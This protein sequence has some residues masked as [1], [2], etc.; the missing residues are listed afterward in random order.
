MCGPPFFQVRRA[1]APA[2]SEVNARPVS[3]ALDCAGDSLQK[4]AMSDLWSALAGD[5]SCPAVAASG[6][7]R[8]ALIARGP[9]GELLHRQRDAE[10]W[11]DFR[12]L[13]VPVARG[14]ASDLPVDWRIAACATAEDEIQLVARSPEG[15]LL[16]GTVRSG[17]FRGFECIGT[18]E[19]PGV[20]VAVPMGLAGAPTACSREPGQMDV[21]AV[22]PAGELLHTSWSGSAFSELESLGG[23]AAPRGADLPICGAISAAACGSSAMAVFA[24]GTAGELLVKWWNAGV[25]APFVP[26]RSPE[27]TDP[28]LRFV[29]VPLP[30]TSAPVAC[31]GGRTRLDVFARGPAGDLLRRIWNGTAWTRAESLGMP[32]STAGK[33]IPLTGFSLACAWGRWRLDVFATAADGKL[34]NASSNGSWSAPAST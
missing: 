11:T 15:E 33:P 21:F 10:A 24:R 4:Q 32:R 31:G 34:Y 13:G 19:G 5:V 29:E 28:A 23:L 7:R 6:E 3:R 14:G 27:E 18:P 25:W 30:L 8:L 26:V 16:H 2:E 22:G 12:S 20:E 1:Y 9:R 17:A